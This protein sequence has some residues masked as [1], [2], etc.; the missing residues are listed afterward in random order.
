LDKA[1]EQ[2]KLLET[3]QA[4]AA[5]QRKVADTTQAMTAA[6]QELLDLETRRQHAAQNALSAVEEK[7]AQAREQNR[8]A[9]EEGNFA[10]ALAAA[11]A[12]AE[13][14][15]SESLA[16]DV[17]VRLKETAETVGAAWRNR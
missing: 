17:I 13:Q 14:E 15:Q 16:R 11:R 3:A 10:G 1:A 8:L 4:H 2:K 9:A 12:R 5:M 7:L 6:K